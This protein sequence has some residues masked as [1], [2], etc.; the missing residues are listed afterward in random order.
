MI[1][2]YMLE[3][4]EVYDKSNN[5]NW[6]NVHWGKVIKNGRPMAINRRDF[7]L[8]IKNN[9]IDIII[10]NEQQYCYTIIWCKS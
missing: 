4:G 7:E 9:N 3:G 1:V 5:W 8:W 6:P 2:L 10:F